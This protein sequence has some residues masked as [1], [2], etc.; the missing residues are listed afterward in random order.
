M[1]SAV[2]REKIQNRSDEVIANL[3]ITLIH[4]CDVLIRGLIE[5]KKRDFIERGGIKEEL[6]RARKD[7]QKR[8]GAYGAIP[9]ERD[10][11]NG[12]SGINGQSASQYSKPIQHISPTAAN[13]KE[14]D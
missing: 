8:N 2:Y 10:G 9:Y 5:W 13:P 14:H 12:Q 11:H 1:E 4:Q 6:Y 3:A 7:W